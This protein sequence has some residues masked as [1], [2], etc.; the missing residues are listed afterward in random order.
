MIESGEF[1][2]GLSRVAS[3]TSQRAPIAQLCHA[4]TKLTLVRI[5]MASRAGQILPMVE[6]SSFGSSFQRFFVAVTTRCRDVAA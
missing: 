2:P 6:H 1:T 5:V 3:L 4:L